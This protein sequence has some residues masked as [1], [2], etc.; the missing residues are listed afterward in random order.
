MTW[1]S[2][3]PSAGRPC[4]ACLSRPEDCGWCF[5]GLHVAFHDLQNA[6]ETAP[7]PDSTN[8]C[9]LVVCLDGDLRI[10]VSGLD[11]QDEFA[12]QAGSCALH[13]HPQ[14]CRRRKCPCCQ[15]AQLFELACPATALH[16]LI[17]DTALGRELEAAI[18]AK[19]P[20]HIQKP[21]RPALH[22][23]LASLREAVSN[24]T[25]GAA[26]LILS[27]ILEAV[28]MLTRGGEQDGGNGVPSET[29]RAVEQARTILEAN[30]TDPPD[31]EHLATTVGMS[32]SK[33][34]QVFPAVCGMPPF[35]YLRR[36]RMERAMM[37]LRHEG[38]SVTE[39]AL[40]VGYSNLS[41]FAKAFAA[42]HGVKPSR[43]R[44]GN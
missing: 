4:S 9:I 2:I 23:A 14:H 18:S 21:L 37:L 39:A 16:T 3:T 17:R 34:K 8:T 26:P 24:A 28:W 6:S 10:S 20:L 38:V 29:R 36:I 33:L 7:L 35:A 31:L 22:Q 15:R 11:G 25:S 27:K 43:V 32:L 42:H 30:M 41:H 40:E 19:R 12:L 5:E 44:R 1:K 13:Y